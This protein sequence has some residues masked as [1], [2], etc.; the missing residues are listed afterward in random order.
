MAGVCGLLLLYYLIKYVDR[1]WKEEKEEQQEINMNH[2]MEME[3][4]TGTDKPMPHVD[5]ETTKKLEMDSKEENK[6]KWDT[7]DLF[8]G[9]LTRLGCQYEIDEND[10]IDFKWQ[11]GYFT[12]DVTNDCPFVVVWYFNW[13]EFELYDV[14][15]WS[16]VKQVINDANINYNIH[17]LYSMNE[18]GGTF[19]VHS[20]KHFL[21]FSEI[22]D[23]EGY[24]QSVLEQ[25]FRIRQYVES[26]IEKLKR[27]E[28][29]V[30][31]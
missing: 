4:K 13:A 19:N 23:V 22:P 20:K 24:L 16:R 18:A 3:L 1:L 12:A 8:L 2:A 9:T 6:E 27:D 17:V 28:E 31:K 26:E 25:F 15:T 11:G 7:R 14:D 30:T 10:R 29:I 5:M 21:F